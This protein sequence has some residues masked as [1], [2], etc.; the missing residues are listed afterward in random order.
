MQGIP[1]I[2]R[3]KTGLRD[4]EPTIEYVSILSFVETT[5]EPRY[6]I[7]GTKQALVAVIADA[8]GELRTAELSELT[9]YDSA[10]ANDAE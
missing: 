8:M 4:V 1:A 3:A 2:Y 9:V 5:F 7:T 10:A 6:E